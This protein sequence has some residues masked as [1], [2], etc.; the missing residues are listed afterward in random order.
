MNKILLG[1]SAAALLL[2][3][4]SCNKSANGPAPTTF[5]D[6]LAVYMGTSQGAM[7][8]E[9]LSQLPPQDR[10]NFKKDD[11]LRGFKQVLMAD[12]GNVGYLYGISVGL[13]FA[14]QLQQWDRDSIDVDRAELFR[15]F[16]KAFK[17]D[18]LN[19]MSTQVAA[20]TFQMLA[21]RAQEF[22]QKRAMAEQA[23][24]QA[25]AAVTAE[26]NIADGKAYVEAQKKAD[27]E[28]KTTESGLSYKV[29]KQGTGAPITD[30]SNVKVHYTGKLIDGT[31]FDS[32]VER[33][34]PADFAVAQVVPGFAEGLKLMTKGAKYVLYIPSSLAYGNNDMG[35]IPPGSTLVFDVEVLDIN[36]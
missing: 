26:K 29:V 20:G 15:Q 31:V 36:K 14:Q 17:A 7:C 22:A 10:A 11:F 12:T 2:A 3:S 4:A 25:A 30:A 9:R 16:A 21:M 8:A 34:E 5:A 35:T 32:S 27:P 6:S 19:A 13:S 23:A 33:G 24:Q 1:C 18:T 28:I